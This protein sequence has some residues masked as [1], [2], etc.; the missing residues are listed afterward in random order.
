MPPAE[1]QVVFLGQ[2]GE[3]RQGKIKS[4]A[5]TS[6]LTAFK[7]KEAPAILGSYNWKQKTLFLFGYVDG[8]ESTE[9]QHHLPAPLEGV[10]YYGDIMVIASTDPRS[11]TSAVSLK[12]SE[13]ET[14]Y[15]ARL[16]G[17]DEE[18][19]ASEEESAVD[20]V[21]AD[22]EAEDEDVDAAGYDKGEDEVE[23]EVEKEDDEIVIEKPVR[24]ARVRKPTSTAHVEEP[25][26]NPDAP[27]EQ[28]PYR[29]R[30][31]SVIDSVL[32]QWI[33]EPDRIRME[34]LIFENALK[35]AD[36]NDVRKSW[37]MQGFRDIYLAVSRRIIGNLDPK[38]YVKNTHALERY[39]EGEL[40]LDQ[41]I[42]QNYYE[43]FPEKWEV[44]VDRQAKRERIQ[45]EG[46]F[47]RATDKWL[48]NGCKMR[49]CTYY[50]LQTRSAD[51]PMTIFIQCLN[52]GKRWTQ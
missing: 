39:N 18:E 11:H 3:I 37:N 52:C 5:P 36:K 30:I 46:D 24:V 28:T 2:K 22:D 40:T 1:I 13:Y 43:L 12:T 51:E 47:S 29:V 35:T 4:T 15:T 48:C 45:L 20:V 42:N 41:L 27:V 17:D 7:K 6:I 26:L 14:F 23:E 38:S 16:E 21:I 49:K 10:T 32:A 34:E 25:E 50:E 19:E 44:M 31:R 9:N 8:K 33:S